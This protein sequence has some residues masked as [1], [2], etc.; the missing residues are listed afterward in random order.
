MEKG[1]IWVDFGSREQLV[2]SDGVGRFS[3]PSRNDNL[4][5][6]ASDLVFSPGKHRHVFELQ[7]GTLFMQLQEVRQILRR[8]DERGHFDFGWLNTFHSFSFGDYHDSDWMGFSDL[9]VINEDWIA[10]GKGFG[11]HGHR[12]MEIV[13]WVLEGAIEHRDSLGNGEALR[14]GEIQ[15]MT[16]G[17]GI[18]H[19]EANPSP[20]ESLHLLQIWL[21]P[22]RLS[23]VPSYEQKVVDPSAM[24]NQFAL[25]AGPEGSNATVSIGQD[26]KIFVGRFLTGAKVS[27]IWNPNRSAWIQ[28]TKGAVEI[29]GVRLVA[30]DAL[31]LVSPGEVMIEILEPSEILAFDLRG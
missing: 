31:G 26:A 14:P 16:A 17:S 15:R 27:K 7:K 19:S 2:F 21:L 10:P 9:R 22:S 30:S 23:S 12:D 20:T 5:A 18:R 11:M 4:G 3:Q 29:A 28:V 1:E 8:G 25:V 24:E 6:D 13:T